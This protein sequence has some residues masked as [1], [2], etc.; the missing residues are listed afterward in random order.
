MQTFIECQDK[1]GSPITPI[2]WHLNNCEVLTKPS[3]A[4]AMLTFNETPNTQMQA[5]LL[6]TRHLEQV[7]VHRRP[8][9]AK[10]T[11]QL[12]RGASACTTATSSRGCCC[13]AAA[14]A[15]AMCFQEAQALLRLS[16]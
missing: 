4:H 2:H 11:V 13:G 1:I 6:R 14:A 10:R 16:C 5:Y 15:H 3:H 12:H 7:L 9:T 8:H